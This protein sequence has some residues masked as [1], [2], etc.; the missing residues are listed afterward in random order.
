[1]T[2]RGGRCFPRRATWVIAR[3][4]RRASSGVMGSM[5]ASPRIP[6]VPKSV[7]SV[8]CVQSRRSARSARSIAKIHKLKF[9]VQVLR[10]SDERDRLLQVVAL[11]SRHTHDLFLDRALNLELRILDEL[12]DLPSVVRVDA[13]FDLGDDLPAAFGALLGVANFEEAQADLATHELFF[14]H[15]DARSDAVLGG[16]GDDELSLALFDLGVG[17]FEVEPLR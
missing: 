15:F 10:S 8:T 6:S 14:E 4:S 11:L 16:R 2:M 9:E 5:L 7:R 17:A 1:M 12:D 3:P 13:L